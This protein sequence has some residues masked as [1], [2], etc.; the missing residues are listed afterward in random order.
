MASQVGQ[1]EIAKWGAVWYEIVIREIHGNNCLV[2]HPQFGAWETW[3]NEIAF[4]HNASNTAWPTDRASTQPEHDP[5]VWQQGIDQSRA[6]ELH[7]NGGNFEGLRVSYAQ[8]VE[9]AHHIAPPRQRTERQ[10]SIALARAKQRFA[11]TPEQQIAEISFV[12][13]EKRR[14]WRRS[15]WQAYVSKVFGNT[16]PRRML[17]YLRTGNIR[18]GERDL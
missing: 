18:I 16:D 9:E 1:G 5:S 12:E 6:P 13:G 15:R 7:M 17:G 2:E 10:V 11:D 8:C 14:T 3:Y 4:F